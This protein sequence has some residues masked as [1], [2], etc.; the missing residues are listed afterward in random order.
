MKLL[1]VDDEE[2]IRLIL[3]VC[4][5]REGYQCL[6]ATTGK[7]ALERAAA[8]QPDVILLDYLLPDMTGEEILNQLRQTPGLQAI[9][10]LCLTAKTDEKIT[11][12]LLA[13][14]A[15]GIL[16]KPFNPATIGQAVKS[17]LS[18]P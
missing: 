15:R 8:N 11:Q 12:S 5:E 10:V 1:I 4:L 6:Y 13:A 9:P 2:D 16:S 17:L 18:Q 14:G 3:T 7:E